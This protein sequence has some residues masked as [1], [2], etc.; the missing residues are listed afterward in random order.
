MR[1]DSEEY[2]V[3]GICEKMNQKPLILLGGG[4]AANRIKDI[5][6]RHIARH[7]DEKEGEILILGFK[8]F[9]VRG[10]NSRGALTPSNIH[11][12]LLGAPQPLHVS[13]P[14]VSRK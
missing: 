5:D 10:T 1:D 7:D 4:D 13:L 14:Y 12:I 3:N 6:S 2:V 8:E 9:C 11:W